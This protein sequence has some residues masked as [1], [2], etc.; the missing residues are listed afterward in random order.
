VTTDRALGFSSLESE[1]STILSV[2]GDIPTWLS[3]TLIRN[4][5]GSFAVGEDREVG[6]W[7]DGLA[8]LHAFS[9]GAGGEED[10]EQEGRGDSELKY[11][12]RFLETDAYR[13]TQAG[14]FAGGFATGETTLRDRLKAFAIGEPYDNTNIVAERVGGIY[15]ALTETPRWVEFDPRSLETLG[16]VQYEG[17]KPS[18]Q[19]SCSHMQRDPWT[20]GL[21]NFEIEFGR[22]SAYHVYEMGAPNRRE[23]VVS[24]PVEEPGYMHSFAL[25]PSFVVLTEFP[26]VVDPTQALKPGKQGPFIENF[27]WKPERGTR[28]FVIDREQG[29]V[30]AAPRTD[31]FFGFHHINAY[32]ADGSDASVEDTAKNSTGA[33]GVSS[34]GRS[35]ANSQDLVIDL[36]TVPDAE[37]LGAASLSDLREGELEV[38]GGSVERFRV[39]IDGRANATIDREEI[40]GG[41]TGL[42]TASPARWCREYRYAYAQGADQPMTDWPKALVKVDVESGEVLEFTD[43]GNYLGEPIFVPRPDPD[44]NENGGSETRCEDDREQ[45]FPVQSGGREYSEDEG[46]V[47]SVALDTETEH[48]WLLVLDGENFTE[49]ARA[50]IPHAI[51][52]D[53]HG[54]YFPELS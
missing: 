21:V 7:F 37:A 52:F 1:V 34:T 18:G 42:P 44:G 33:G 14:E 6:H 28:F 23:H 49:R 9:F 22:R 17:P 35:D 12:N 13:A 41:A 39:R 53:F 50:A 29:E 19:L 32:E 46:V 31:A 3:G 15:L 47:L 48:S 20:G 27:E 40:Y 5:P 30:I 26:L 51:P 11:R 8:M 16:D 38:P 54:R 43:E 45:R 24:I 4:G 36:E 2:E 25:T 10:S